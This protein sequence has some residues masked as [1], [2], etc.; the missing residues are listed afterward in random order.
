MAVGVGY[1][2]AGQA[3]TGT[4]LDRQVRRAQHCHGRLVRDVIAGEEHAAAR[5]GLEEGPQ[6]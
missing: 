6:C 2:V 1:A 4:H 3:R 5:V